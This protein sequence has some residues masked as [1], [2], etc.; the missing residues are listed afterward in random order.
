MMVVF[1]KDP[2]DSSTLDAFDF[3]GS[4]DSR[5]P[6]NNAAVLKDTSDKSKIES[7][8]LFRVFDEMQSSFH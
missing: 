2:L 1:S 6:P 8:F 7:S 3:I 5:W 4:C